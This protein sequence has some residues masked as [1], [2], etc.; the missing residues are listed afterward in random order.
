M[1]AGTFYNLL[2]YVR[3]SRS[4]R[5]L[6]ASLASPQA[7]QCITRKV[8]IR[9]PLTTAECTCCFPASRF[10]PV[11]VWAVGCLYAEMLTSEPLFPGESDLDQLY[12]ILKCFG[13]V[14][15]PVRPTISCP[16]PGLLP[17]APL[18]ST[19]AALFYRLSCVVCS[20]RRCAIATDR[21][22]AAKWARIY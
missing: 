9:R 4:S 5:R 2:C 19:S 18:S 21:F 16:R 12:H 13:T 7:H 17:V 1:L 15:G 22:V 3:W 10:R 14:P 11:D 6:V 20:S 8:A